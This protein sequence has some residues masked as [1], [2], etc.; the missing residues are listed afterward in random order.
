V[1]PTRWAL[2]AACA[3]A[4]CFRALVP[5]YNVFQA[6]FINFQE[7]DAWF[8]VRVMEHL[9]R[10]FP[11]RLHVDPY[12]SIL[13]GQRVD[14]GP[15]FDWIPAL[16][17]LPWPD[18]LQAI[19]AWYPAI[20]GVFIILAVFY[21]ARALFDETTA[22]LAALVAA[23]L[24]GHFLAVSSLGFTDHHV[25]ESLLSLLVLYFLVQRRHIAAGLTLA[26]YLLTFVGG[27]FLVAIVIAWAAYGF[28]R[29]PQ[30][31]DYAPNLPIVFAIPLLC[32]APFHQ[33]L[34]MEYTLA[35]L[36]GG[37]ALTAGA[38]LC[39]RF[40]YPRA[41]W[42][43][44][45][46]AAAITVFVA[47]PQSLQI[48]RYLAP[49]RSGA[50]AGVGELQSMWF[51]KGYFSLEWPWLEFGGVLIL[52]MAGIPVLLEIATRNR[53][54]ELALFTLWSLSVFLMAMMQVRMA[55]YFAP[56]AAIVTAYLLVRAWTT[57]T[58]KQ[59][60]LVALA[61]LALVFAPNGWRLII[62][63][64]ASPVAVPSPWRDALDWLRTHSPEPFGDPNAYYATNID[65]QSAKYGVLSWWDYGYWITA[66]GRRVPLTNPTQKNASVAASFFLAQSEP[67]ALKV[68]EQW[69]QRYVIMDDRL[70]AAIFPVLF[71]FHPSA[72]RA[73]YLVE[74]YERQ[75]DGKLELR[76]FYREAYYQTM[77]ARLGRGGASAA[78]TG[79]SS[80]VLLSAPGAVYKQIAHFTN[81][82]DAQRIQQR[83][84]REGCV[85]VGDKPDQPIFPIDPLATLKQVYPTTRGPA[86][87]S[88]FDR[89]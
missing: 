31:D 30:D 61:A 12:G 35:A 24:P 33:I 34:W 60:P 69:R 81:I 50:A 52:A 65:P 42:L 41:I 17:A 77:A 16:L 79:P 75:P 15:F 66:I 51:I 46:A 9:V 86:S 70:A 10:H 28:L 43:T 36:A 26:A 57:V 71:N 39:R 19:A 49:S 29:Y 23:V 80:V 48:L 4:F 83:C 58:L 2:A 18:E 25:M 6:G 72:R 32:A 5:F 63:A 3:I 56:A 74:G 40:P 37:I 82:Q 27:A 78:G 64:P 55:Y 68:M 87:V 11:F 38:T 88:I 13:D 20:L 59:R 22:A 89:N 1:N 67:E 21:L 14:T 62:G 44:A 54:P 47:L 85:L 45:I 84:A 53:R 76:R 8:H 7:T 73:D